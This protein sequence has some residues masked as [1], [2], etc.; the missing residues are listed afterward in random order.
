MGNARRIFEEFTEGGLDRIQKCVE[1]PKQEENLYIDFKEDGG[2]VDNKKNLSKA[3]SG[4]ANSEGGILIWGVSCTSSA[5]KPDV[6]DKLCPIKNLRKFHTDLQSWTSQLVSPGVEGVEHYL[7]YETKDD[8]SDKGYIISYVPQSDLVH[9]AT[10]KDLH[11]YY[12]RSGS[13]FPKMP[14]FMVADRY[15]RRPHPKLQLDCK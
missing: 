5:D 15:G 7:L 11:R 13:S 1:L 10:G 12:F 14:S 9:M 2:D 6:A 3:L 4:F 8:A